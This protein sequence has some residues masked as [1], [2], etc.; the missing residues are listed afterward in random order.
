M[1]YFEYHN[2]SF[3]AKD[4]YEA[5][6]SKNKKTVN[7]VND[8]LINLR[9]AVNKKTIPENKSRWSNQNCWKKSFR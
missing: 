9:N 7:M 4:L 3:L 1:D 2:Q 5:N 6:Q 8:A